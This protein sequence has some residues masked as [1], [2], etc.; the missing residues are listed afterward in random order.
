MYPNL[1]KLMAC[2]PKAPSKMPRRNTFSRM[3]KYFRAEL[4]EDTLFAAV[5]FG[6]PFWLMYQLFVEAAK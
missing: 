1:Q 3:C 5:V 4:I 6:V 2:K